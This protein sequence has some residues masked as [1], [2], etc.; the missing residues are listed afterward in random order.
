M[1]GIAAWFFFLA[2][3]AFMIRRNDT[4]NT[5]INV[6][7]FVLMFVSSMFY[8]LD[9][10]P[11]W[12]KM[13]AYANPLTWHTDVLRYLTIGVGNKDLFMPEIF[14]FSI[15]LATTFWFAVK[16]LKKTA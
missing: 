3:F 12:L 7:Y 14:G 16:T 10:V 2:T 15:F 1:A 8:P 6:A 9:A 11:Q 4:F 5:F 13:F